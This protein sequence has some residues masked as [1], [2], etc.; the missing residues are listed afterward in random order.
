MKRILFCLILVLIIA[1]T[2]IKEPIIVISF[3]TEYPYGMGFPNS[4]TEQ[5]KQG[6]IP[7]QE[8][9][10]N[11]VKRINEIGIKHKDSFQFNFVGR[12]VED[13]PEL[14]KEIMKN[15]GVSCHTYSHKNQLD[16]DYESKLSELKRCK[17]VLEGITGKKIIGNRFPYT[18]YNNESFKALK[19]AGY[20]WDYSVWTDR[21]RLRPF[22]YEGITEYPI[23]PI[24]DDW[25]YFVR[26]K[27]KDADKF[28]GL[29]DQDISKLGEDSVYVIILHPWVLATDSLRID[30]LE[31]FVSGHK[32]I[33]SMDQIHKN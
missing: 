9:W 4:F 17:R 8:Q 21:A 16:L 15:N 12:T 23:S 27:N 7:T 25:D 3:D 29:L 24:T 22:D 20:E 1:C 10:E 2:P 18:K 11:A 33:K 13:N 28:F 6:F 14:V 19:E 32:N 31:R 30:A 26:N 5:E